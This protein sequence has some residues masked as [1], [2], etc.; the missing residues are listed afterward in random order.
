MIAQDPSKNDRH[1]E[2]QKRPVGY[3]VCMVYGDNREKSV[4]LKALYPK[5]NFRVYKTKKEAEKQ[6]LLYAK[7]NGYEIHTTAAKKEALSA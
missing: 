5:G 4:T 7:R 2:V 1:Y 3:M 6:L